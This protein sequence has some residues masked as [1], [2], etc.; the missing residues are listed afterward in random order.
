MYINIIGTGYV[1]LVTGACFA[2]KGHKV[3]CLDIDKSKIDLLNDNKIP[4]FEPGLFELIQEHKQNIFFRYMHEYPNAD[5]V[6]I[7]V[8]TPPKQD[9]STDL[10]YVKSVAEFLTKHSRVPTVIKSTVPV[11]TARMVSEILKSEVISNPEFLREGS[12]VRDFLSPDRIVIGCKSKE[13]KNLIKK[14]YKGFNAPIRF[15]SN[16]SAELT[17]YVANSFLAV[18]ISYINEIANLC[19]KSGADINDV[20]MAVGDDVRI[21]HGSFHPGIGFGGSCFPK[22]VSS[23]LY[24]AKTNDTRLLVLEYAQKAND[25]QKQILAKRVLDRFK[26]LSGKKIAIWGISFKPGTDDTR[27][28]SS[29]STIK[30]LK[31]L[32]AEVVAYDPHAT[33]GDVH[34]THDKLDA[35]YGA[36]ALL[37]V[38]EWQE[39]IDPDWKEIFK[40]MLTPV[41]FDGRNMWDP[42]HVRS[43]GFE[44]YGMGNQ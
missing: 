23:L 7:A 44:Y 30:Y 37:L 2:S 5:L 22:D 21:G 9:G 27:E 36:D 8:G 17:K 24:Q 29:V 42:N 10:S 35:I 38:T 1:G 40:R 14:L 34:Q 39:F 16:E 26:C 20:R 11:G 19:T 33:Y 43:F 31:S 13:S 32:G 6:V 15:M 28:A 18:K 12:S 25:L 3:T 41:I 4:I